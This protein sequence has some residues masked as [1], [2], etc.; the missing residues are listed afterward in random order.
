VA[1]YSLLIKASA[2]KE[3]EATPKKDRERLA[4]RIKRLAAAPRPPGSEK[5][6]GEEKYRICQG[7]YRILYLIEDAISTVTVVKIGHRREVYRN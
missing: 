2:A 7:D 1:S 4:A 5:L 3:L 6:S